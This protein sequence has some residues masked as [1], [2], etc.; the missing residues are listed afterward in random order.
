MASYTNRR[1]K[2][3]IGGCFVDVVL[4]RFIHNLQISKRHFCQKLRKIELKLQH[5]ILITLE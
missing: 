3:K 2:H 4:D 5:L 1:G